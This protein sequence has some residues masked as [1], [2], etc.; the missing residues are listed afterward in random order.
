[1]LATALSVVAL[2]Q[3]SPAGPT[4]ADTRAWWQRTSVLSADSMEGRDAG[5]RG[6]VRAARHVARWLAAVG[7]KPLGGGSWYQ[8]VPMEEVAVTRVVRQAQATVNSRDGRPS[9]RLRNPV[10]CVLDGRCRRRR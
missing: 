5:S 1:M 9:D 10:E 6:H 7:V 3:G 4:D 8:W 2:L